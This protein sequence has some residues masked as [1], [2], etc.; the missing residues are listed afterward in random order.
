M[1]NTNSPF[2]FRWHGIGGDGATPASG[3]VTVKVAS[4]NTNTFGQG[5]PLM[6]LNTGY[7]DAFT[8]TTSGYALVGIFETCEYYST[9]QG[10]KVYRNYWPG[11]DATGDVTVHMTSCL[12]AI[13]PQ[14]LVQSSGASAVTLSSV[15]LNTDIYAG[16]STAGTASGGFYRS[17]CKTAALSAFSTT[18]TL[19]F[20]IVG[21]YSDIAAPGSPGADTASSYNWLL[22]EPNNYGA[23]GV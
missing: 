23:Q 10:R 2:G 19:P 15:G 20:R 18:T 7:V 4:T 1:S 12:G 14:F 16:S 8:A 6:R 17:A 9:S 13:N 5:D 3:L 11:S 21:L 22:V